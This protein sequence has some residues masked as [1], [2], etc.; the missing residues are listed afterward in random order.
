GTG[1]AQLSVQAG[2]TSDTGGTPILVRGR[3]SEPAAGELRVTVNGRIV[4]AGWEADGSFAA[5]CEVD[6][7][8]LYRFH[9]LWRGPYG[10][11]VT[12]MVELSDGRTFGGWRQTGS[13]E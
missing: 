1:I 5:T 7:R 12:A 2:P 11:V 9:S 4:P 13:V 10:A 3:L 8:E 6:S